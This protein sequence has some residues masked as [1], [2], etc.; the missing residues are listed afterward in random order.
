MDPL[1]KL[2]THWEALHTFNPA[3]VVSGGKVILLY[4][5]EDDSGDMKIGGH[6][7]RLGMAVSSDGVHFSEMPA[8]VFYPANDGQQDRES[9]GGTEDPR[10]VVREDGTYILTY[11]QWSRRRRIFSIGVASSKDL[12]HW[13]KYGPA[14]GSTGRYADF[15]YKSAGIVTG[16]KNGRLVAVRIH[17]KYWMYWGEGQVHLATSDDLIHWLP[18]ADKSGHP[19]VLLDKRLHASDSGFLE[20][21]PPA[22]VTKDG[23]V[24]LYNAK[25]AADKTKD[26][27]VGASA[28]SVQEALFSID[29]LSRLIG[30]T[31]KPVLAPALEWEKSGQYP[32]GT[33]FAEGLIPFRG[34]WW[35]YYGSADSFVGAA[36][37][38]SIA[39]HEA[40]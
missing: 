24:L 11:T 6:V 36:T 14:F 16:F 29:D 32:S 13:M 19:L 12:K 25:N 27:K 3:S 9:P 7:S 40:K 8:P 4:R 22:V 5:A 30:R 17:E 18:V 35:V 39:A 31:Q 1:S 37:C 34:R 10:L 15:K 28:Y 20:T 23:V 38:G 33:T 2:P 26:P 21:G